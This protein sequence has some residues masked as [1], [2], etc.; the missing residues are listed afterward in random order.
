MAAADETPDILQRILA[1][2]REVIT[3]RHGQEPLASVA[4]RVAET[5]DF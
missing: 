3:E 2:K 5:V 1:R 4:E